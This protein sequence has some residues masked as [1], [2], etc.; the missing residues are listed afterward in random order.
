MEEELRDMKAHKAYYNMLHFVS[1]AQQG[2]P[3]LCPCGSI[4]KEFVDEEDTYDY[5]PGKIYFICKD[6]QND[7]LHFRQPWVMGGQQEIERLKQRFHEQEKLLRECDAQVKMML[8]RVSELE[9]LCNAYTELND[10]VVQRQRF[11][12][13]LKD[14]QS[15]DDEAMA[16]D[17]TFCNALE[18]GLAPTGG[19]GLGIDRLAMLLTDSQ[20]IKEVILF[21]A[22][23]PQ[24]DPASVKGS[25]QP[26]KKGE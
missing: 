3:K 17:E 13:Q 25:L 9:R 10:P 14:R 15:G 24:D 20:N 7:G 18:Y 22:M 11:A 8:Q 16:L 19:W 6:Y 1:D 21:P 2:I 26:E 5:L 4:T 12:D 23:R